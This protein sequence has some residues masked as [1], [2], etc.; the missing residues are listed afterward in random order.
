MSYVNN[1]T[2]TLDNT[3]EL[4]QDDNENDASFSMTQDVVEMVFWVLSCSLSIFG[5]VAILNIAR[6][7]LH[8][9]YQRFIGNLSLVIAIVSLLNASHP[10]LIPADSEGG[11]DRPWVFGNEATCSALGF[12][13]ICG[14]MMISLWSTSLGLYFYFSI[15]NDKLKRN[16]LARRAS[17]SRSN[18]DQG[19]RL[20]SI[21]NSMGMAERMALLFNWAFP[22]LWG[23]VA[24][25]TKI[26]G[27][28]PHLHVCII[29]DPC[30]QENDNI[31]ALEG[32]DSTPAPPEGCRYSTS[33]EQYVT[34]LSRLFGRV[35]VGMILLLQLV[36]IAATISV[37]RH[38]KRITMKSAQYGSQQ[39]S[40]EACQRLRATFVQCLLYTMI[41][42]NVLFFWVLGMS[43]LTSKRDG[44]LPVGNFLLRCI[45]VFVRGSQG[46]FN[47]FIYFRPRVSQLREKHPEV[48]SYMTLLRMALFLQDEDSLKLSYPRSNDLPSSSGH[49]LGRMFQQGTNSQQNKTL[50]SCEMSGDIASSSNIV[51][52]G[53]SPDIEQPEETSNFNKTSSVDGN[54]AVDENTGRS[55]DLHGSRCDENSPA[56]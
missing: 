44:A 10:F 31:F 9:P 42:A 19:S 21:L 27:F 7:K 16:Y 15:S 8:Q 39:L 5:C 43:R 20:R 28:H 12:V 40:P 38:V 56:T 52:S 50:V 6:K 11:L 46:I 48:G 35:H 18:A 14:Y 34:D 25:S 47:A 36:G 49:S 17:T 29:Y 26:L 54:L 4:Q 22:I 41:Y 1:T 37:Y 24:V 33:K 30:E 32:G 45:F 53:S 51:A 2:M 23:T 55:N 3:N 13:A